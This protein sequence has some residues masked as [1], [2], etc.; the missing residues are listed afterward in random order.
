MLPDNRAFPASDGDRTDPAAPPPRPLL[1]RT[2]DVCA[3]LNLSKST[4]HRLLA[5]RLL[6]SV[7]VGGS[8]RFFYRDVEQFAQDLADGRVHLDSLGGIR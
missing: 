4:V 3:V 8:R 2:D 7:K 1:L 6:P 5:L